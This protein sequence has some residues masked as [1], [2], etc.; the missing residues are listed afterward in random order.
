MPSRIWTNHILPFK[1]R[2]EVA[3]GNANFS[4]A[5]NNGIA[6]RGTAETRIKG[7]I[8]FGQASILIV[9]AAV[10]PVSRQ[11]RIKC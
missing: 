1:N 7:G 10:T 4:S 9:S 11:N 5:P 8:D 6:S 2:G 3:L